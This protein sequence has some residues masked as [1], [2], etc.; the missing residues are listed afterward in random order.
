MAREGGRR[1]GRSGGRAGGRGAARGPQLTQ[2]PWRQVTNPYEPIR[3]LSEDQIDAIA[4]TAFRI[5]EEIGM[6]FMHPEA[7]EFLTKAGADVEAGTE[8]VRFDR[9]LIQ[10]TLANAPAS[11]TVRA[12]NPVHNLTFGGNHINFGSVA[13]APN[14]SDL[15]G[16]RRSGAQADYR[17]F[18]RLSQAINSVHLL[19]GYPVE[20]ID[21]PP[22]TRHLDCIRDF[23]DPDRQGLSRLFPGT[24]AHSRC[25][26]R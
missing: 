15:E 24:D 2:L 20:P 25:A 8:R 21:L 7:L 1:G 23:P 4:D 13:S 9:G 19:S 12:R 11:F 26:W 10:E 14:C 6:D 5:L 22:A 3:V 16:G 18:L 17:N